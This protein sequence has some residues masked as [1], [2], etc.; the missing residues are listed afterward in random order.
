MTIISLIVAMDENGGIGHKNQLLCH[1]PED[2]KHF[3]KLTLGKPIIMGYKTFQSIGRP[4]PGRLNIV[5]TSQERTIDGVTIAHTMQQ[6]L[7]IAGAVPEVMIIGGSTLFLQYLDLAQQ[8][9]LTRIH[10][11]FD[12]DAFF[13]K[14]DSARWSTHE[15]ANKKHDEKNAYDMTFFLLKRT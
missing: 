9:Y 15:L 5:L 4:L 14:L 11:K 3:K 12:A 1:L 13:P 6:A 10:H 7:N 8:I 2:L